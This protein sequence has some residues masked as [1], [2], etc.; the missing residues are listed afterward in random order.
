MGP[1]ITHQANRLK[2]IKVSFSADGT[3]AV[4]AQRGR[5]SNTGVGPLSPPTP[6]TPTSPYASSDARFGVVFSRRRI[7]CGQWWNGVWKGF[8][9]EGEDCATRHCA[10]FGS[11]VAGLVFRQS[12]LHSLT[13]AF[14]PARPVL[15][16][17]VSLPARGSLSSQLT[18][19][20]S[21]VN[22]QKCRRQNVLQY[23]KSLRLDGF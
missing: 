15:Y 19:N 4:I 3:D 6:T 21:A 23:R 5:H 11:G 13:L 7:C 17:C 12:Q 10:H 9:M 20:V 18:Q 1:T 8:V 14:V 2:P 22:T 16:C